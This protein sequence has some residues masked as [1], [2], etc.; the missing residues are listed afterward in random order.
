MSIHEV[1]HA[2][3]S[4]PT[5]QAVIQAIHSGRWHAV[6]DSSVDPYA[7]EAYAKVKAD[8]TVNES[9]GIVLRNGRIAMPGALQVR[10]VQLAHEGHQGLTKT[11]ALIREKVWFPGI[12]RLTESQTRSCLPCQASTLLPSRE[13]LEMS[14]LPDSPW[15]E[16]SAD[17]ATLDTGEYLLVLIDDY[18]RFPVVEIISSTSSAAT[19]PRIDKIFAEFGVA[20]C[21]RT[22]NG[23]PFNSHEFRKFAN[24]LGFRHQKITPLWPRA[25]GE[26]ERFMRTIKKVIKTSA[27]AGMNWKE[28]MNKFLRNYR[29]TPHC[30][31]GVAPATLLFNRPIRT[32]LPEI[33]FR[34]EDEA[35]NNVRNR[36]AERK[37]V[38]K[39]YADNKSYVKPSTLQ[40]GDTVL[41]RTSTSGMK[42]SQPPYE[43]KPLQVVRK[44]GSMITAAGD[45]TRGFITRNSSFFKLFDGSPK[46]DPVEA[47]SQPET[48]TTGEMEINDDSREMSVEDM[49]RTR[50][51]TT[52]AGTNCPPKSHL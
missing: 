39:N 14:R 16:V 26:V 30:T 46:Q 20:K 29:A 31:T 13:P 49:S 25:N 38:M 45:E 27:V 5:L 50:T 22:D 18:S 24:K 12:D 36:D 8:L 48:R 43:M 3:Q 42:K 1:Q 34:V 17:F 37:T 10:A 51:T 32:K 35:G 21:L 6:Q 40:V 41:V 23:P 52:R 2:T 28:E 11:K 4:D 44:Q 15:L 7:F 19:I 33:S 9:N 47:K